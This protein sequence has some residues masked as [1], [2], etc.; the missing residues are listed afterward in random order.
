MK[1]WLGGGLM[2]TFLVPASLF[3]AGFLLHPL[4]VRFPPS[5]P[6]SH[7]GSFWWQDPAP[8]CKDR[9]SCK[10]SGAPTWPHPSRQASDPGCRQGRGFKAAS[11]PAAGSSP[12]QACSAVNTRLAALPCPRRC[13]AAQIKDTS[14]GRSPLLRPQQAV[15]RRLVDTLPALEYPQTSLPK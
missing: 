5:T 15:G 6:P 12:Q 14:A 3:K 13:L 8:C 1:I 9:G 7:D 10:L 4:F 2:A 11:T